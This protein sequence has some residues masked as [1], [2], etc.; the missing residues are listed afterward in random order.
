MTLIAPVGRL[1]DRAARR[2][3]YRVFPDWVLHP[4]QV[5][6][7]DSIGK[8]DTAEAVPGADLDELRRDNPRLLELKNL[9]ANL[10]ETLR[11]PLVWTQEAASSPALTRFRGHNMWI[12]QQGDPHLDQRA[13]LLAAYYILAN[14]RLGLMDKL[15]EDGAFGAITFQVA[16]R[17]VS[18]DLLDSILEI[19]FL[20][21][22]LHIAAR[23]D[24]TILDI[25]AGYGRLAHRMLTAFPSLTR[26]LCTDAIPE[27]TF[28]CEY[29]LQFRGLDSKSRAV[30][31][32]EIDKTLAVINVDLALNIHSFS[33]CT[34]NAVQ[35]WLDRLAAHEVRYFM[36]VP[37]TGNHGGQLLVNNVGAD[38]LPVIERS[39]YR[40]IA[41]E[42][43]YRDPD[44][45]K[46]ALSPTWYWL[47]ERGGGMYVRLPLRRQP[48][49]VVIGGAPLAMRQS[50][51]SGT[52]LPTGSCS[53]LGQ[54]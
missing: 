53:S 16:G 43:K 13:Y 35:W 49:D 5:A 14:D 17:R 37:N 28:V 2:V 23:P 33:E 52:Y 41:R 32:L 30:T 26:Y 51:V 8:S 9:Y 44:V 20:D 36:I 25:G 22:H 39:G 18:R 10:D 15:A 42:P 11:T 19:D 54:F 1:F 29:Y 38:M 24:F 4:S 47:F 48:D 40:L 31:P 45:Q 12:F 3:G 6:E 7:I 50:P 34:L 46:L 21:R 27:S